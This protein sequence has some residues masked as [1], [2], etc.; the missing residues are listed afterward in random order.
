MKY[1]ILILC[2]S[3]LALLS[4]SQYG[5]VVANQTAYSKT[6]ITFDLPVPMPDGIY[7]V[8]EKGKPIPIH[9]IVD[10]LNL[11]APHGWGLVNAYAVSG[12]Q[13]IVHYYVISRETPE[14]EAEEEKPPSVENKE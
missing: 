7:E 12:G 3:P 14:P 8:D 9:S 10:A 2:L 5:L 13:N 6:R 11:L 1:L 4:Q